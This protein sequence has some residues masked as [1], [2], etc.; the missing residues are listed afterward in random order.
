MKISTVW[1][2]LGAIVAV[3]I[4]WWIVSAVFSIAWIAVKAFVVI[5]VASIVYGVIKAAFRRI[6]R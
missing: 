6:N 3:I 1:S 5:A 4:A 2:V